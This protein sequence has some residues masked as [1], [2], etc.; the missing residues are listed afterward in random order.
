MKRFDCLVAVLIVAVWTHERI[1]RD[2]F[3]HFG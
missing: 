3:V 2:R 1:C